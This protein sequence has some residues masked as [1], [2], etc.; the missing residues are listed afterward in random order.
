MLNFI[1]LVMFNGA[2]DIL[3]IKHDTITGKEIETK[4]G[5]TIK[6]LAKGE[7]SEISFS[8]LTL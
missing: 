1:P 4:I 3:K 8:V 6:I 2:I 7:S 5:E